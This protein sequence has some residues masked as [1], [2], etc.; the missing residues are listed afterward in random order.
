MI[1]SI[2]CLFCIKKAHVY[3]CV[4]INGYHE[5]ALCV[6][7]MELV[8][9]LYFIFHFSYIF[10]VK[11]FFFVMHWDEEGWGEFRIPPPPG[12]VNNGGSA[13]GTRTVRSWRLYWESGKLYSARLARKK[14]AAD[15]TLGSKE[16][17][18]ELSEV[19][20]VVFIHNFCQLVI[21]RS[22]VGVLSAGRIVRCIYS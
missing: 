15:V 14:C 4:L 10:H 6:I 16:K 21:L 22:L 19:A 2:K 9:H 7:V 17:D 11:I 5:Q 13:G 3:R 1:N 12:W 8:F 18:L 20:G